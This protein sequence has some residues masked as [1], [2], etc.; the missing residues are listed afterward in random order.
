MNRIKRKTVMTE[1]RDYVMIGIGMLSY[2]IG[3]NVFLLPNSITTGGVPGISSVV[4]W[5]TGLPVQVTYFTINAA[6]LIAA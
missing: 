6:L 5:A 2:C 3:W 4:F 1:L